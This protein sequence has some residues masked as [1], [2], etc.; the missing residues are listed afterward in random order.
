MPYPAPCFHCHKMFHR[1]TRTVKLC[2]DCYTE[3]QSTAALKS[4]LTR[5][6]EMLKDTKFRLL[7]NDN[8][9]DINLL[10]EKELEEDIERIEKQLAIKD[11]KKC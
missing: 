7:Q 3:A 8:N 11:G 6:R 9:R 1:E 10:K 5:K 2:P 4:R